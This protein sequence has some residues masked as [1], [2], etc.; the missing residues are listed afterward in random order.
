MD[1]RPTTLTE[2]AAHNGVGRINAPVGAAGESEY[3]NPFTSL[4]AADEVEP[5]ARITQNKR[6]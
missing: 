6:W 5:A 1:F 2:E 3:V 4:R